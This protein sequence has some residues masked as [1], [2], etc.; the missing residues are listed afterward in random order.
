[1]ATNKHPKFISNKSVQY[2]VWNKL[3]GILVDWKILKNGVIQATYTRKSLVKGLLED[4][5]CSRFISQKSIANSAVALRSD[6]SKQLKLV[7]Y[8]GSSV[9]HRVLDDNGSTKYVCSYQSCN[10][11]DFVGNQLSLSYGFN[12][13]KHTIASAKL[14]RIASSLNELKAVMKRQ[15]EVMIHG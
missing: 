7:P 12:I 4:V 2:Y 13:C 5:K 11:P 14:D 1:M 3:G 10:C 9:G 8:A 15:S 6:A